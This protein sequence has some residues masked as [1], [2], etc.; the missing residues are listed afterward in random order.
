MIMFKNKPT[1]R[2]FAHSSF[3]DRYGARCSVQKSSIAFEECIWFGVDDPKPQILCSH[4]ER[5]GVARQ[6]STGWQPYKIPEDVLLT[7]R[8]HLTQ[9]Q[10]RELIPVL[11][12]FVDTGELP[13]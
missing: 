10:V 1:L 3:K 5:N 4:A 8:M 13:E 7:T 11:Q 6:N 12:H 2:G 9:E